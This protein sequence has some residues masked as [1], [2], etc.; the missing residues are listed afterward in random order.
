MTINIGVPLSQINLK[1]PFIAEWALTRLRGLV[2]IDEVQA[3][4]IE[5]QLFNDISIKYLLNNSGKDYLARI[6]NQ[7]SSDRFATNLKTLISKWPDW[8]DSRANWSARIIS[9][10]CPQEA[11]KLFSTYLE[12]DSDPFLDINKCF[13]IIGSLDFLRREDSKFISSNI[14]DSYF[15]ISRSEMTD[16]LFSLLMLEMAWNFNHPKFDNLLCK[17]LENS[18]EKSEDKYMNT[19]SKLSLTLVGSNADYYFVSDHYSDHTEQR[20]ESMSIFFKELTPLRAIDEA[21]ESLKKHNYQNIENLFQGYGN[22]ILNTKVKDILDALLHN[23]N[24]IKKLDKKKQEPFFYAFIFGC[25]INSFRTN[26]IELKN[27]HLKQV[28]DAFSADIEQ[29]SFF[30]IYVSHLKENN[31]EEVTQLLIESLNS[32]INNLGGVYIINTMGKLRYDKF[33]IP[34]LNALSNDTDRIYCA[35]EKALL[36]Y[37]DKA[38]EGLKLDYQKMNESAKISALSISSK[39]GGLKA[40]EFLDDIFEDRWKRDKEGILQAIKSAPDVRFIKRLEPYINKKQF[41]I[42]H[43]YIILNKLLNTNGPKIDVMVKKALKHEKEN[44]ENR[45][46]FDS[47]RVLDT[48]KPYIDLELE[49]ENCGD[50]NIYRVKEILVSSKEGIKPFVFDELTCINC[51]KI[52]AFSL[53]SKGYISLTAETIRLCILKGD[54]ELIAARKISPI[55]QVTIGCQGK[56]MGIEDGI[57]NYINDIDKNPL[58]V[59]NYIGL[60]NIYRHTKKFTMAE[61]YYKK[62]LELDPIYIEP[63]YSLAVIAKKQK[64]YQS[65]FRWLEKGKKCIRFAKYREDFDMG[66]A[67]FS[68]SYTAFF[69]ELIRELDLKKPFLHPRVFTAKIGRNEPCPC[70]SGKKYKKCCLLRE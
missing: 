7:L 34:L 10:L 5:T 64:D 18:M 2:E 56:E 60:G 50:Q 23:K 27:L 3:E 61:E 15:Q 52:S 57:Q 67:E 40:V 48:V 33:I 26:E 32:K 16:S 21:I 47:G 35:V 45:E 58:K 55:K 4:H 51:K 49:C 1:D 66:N 24:I 41:M 63:Y 59:D 9:K 37:G 30:D 70:G 43:T 46:A 38:I 6:F 68:V 54:D 22:V 12:S 19:L 28:I 69:N 20:Y 11:S 53:T 8:Q 39:I 31:K 44:E 17:F 29:I 13:G 62:A 36:N 42:D 25:L 65:A 14:I